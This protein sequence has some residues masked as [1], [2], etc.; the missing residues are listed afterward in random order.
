ML[1]KLSQDPQLKGTQF[2]ALGDYPLKD[3]SEQMRGALAQTKSGE[4]AMPFQSEA[5]IEIIARCDKRAPPPRMAFKLPT[6]DEIH[7]NLFQEQI[8]AM[9]RGFMRDLRRSANIQ[10]RDN[11]VMD[12]ALIQ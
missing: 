2:Y 11:N 6:E 5:G 9:A 12:A 7:D 1:Q 4:V 8:A 3:A 10:Q